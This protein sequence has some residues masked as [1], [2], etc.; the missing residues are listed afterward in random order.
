MRVAAR[1]VSDRDGAERERGVRRH[2]RSPAVGARAAGVEREIDHDRNGHAP[3]RRRRGNRQP[4]TFAQLAEVELALGLEPDDQEEQRHQPLVD[5]VAQVERDA[6]AADRHRQLRGPQRF[7]GVRPRRVG[8]DEREHGAGQQHARAAGLRA[9]EVAHRR[10]QASRPGC[11]ACV[12]RGRRL[13]LRRRATPRMPDGAPPRPGHQAI[14]PRRRPRGSTVHTDGDACPVHRRYRRPTGRRLACRPAA[15]A[16]RRARRR[17]GG[18]QRG[19][20]RRGRC[21]HDRR[22]GRAAAGSRC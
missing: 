18:G 1:G 9:E 11:A 3:E 13:R 20:L 17:P 2:R 12:A 16:A 4:P 15:G 7:I 10:R 14:I 8:P 22:S 5:P 21:E 19:E 6:V